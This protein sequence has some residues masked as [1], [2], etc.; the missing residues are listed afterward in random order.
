MRVTTAIAAV[1][2]ATETAT[3]ETA[4]AIETC[5]ATVRGIRAGTAVHAATIR[6][7]KTV[8][9]NQIAAR[10]SPEPRARGRTKYPARSKHFGRIKRLVLQTKRPDPTNR[11]APINPATKASDPPTSAASEEDEAVAAAVA[12]D[13]MAAKT[14]RMARDRT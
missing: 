4:T 1:R 10:I 2:I 11:H 7:R 9:D 3:G 8:P 13:A 6:V 12:A 5:D 14:A